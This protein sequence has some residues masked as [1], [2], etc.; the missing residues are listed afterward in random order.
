[1]TVRVIHTKKGLWE[2]QWYTTEHPRYHRAAIAI[3]L[4][5]QTHIEGYAVRSTQQQQR[6]G[7]LVPALPRP[8]LDNPSGQTCLLASSELDCAARDRRQGPPAG[9]RCSLGRVRRESREQC[10]SAVECTQFQDFEQASTIS[11]GVRNGCIVFYAQFS[12]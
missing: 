6:S 1:M 7:G 3:D 5:G 2:C 9:P 11:S 12:K 10:L 4:G 8:K